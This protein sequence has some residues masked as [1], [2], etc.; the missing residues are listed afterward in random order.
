MKIQRCLHQI[1]KPTRKNLS[2]IEGVGEC[3]ECEYNEEENIK[4][5]KYTIVNLSIEEIEDGHID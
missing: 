5:K 4:C 1:I 3:I 2:F